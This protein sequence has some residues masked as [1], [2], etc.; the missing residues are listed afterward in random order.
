[1]QRQGSKA[2]KSRG[3]TQ[4]IEPLEVEI[5][6]HL[7]RRCNSTFRSRTIDDSRREY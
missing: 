1:M 3:R 2:G 7:Q 6:Q 5:Q 4:K